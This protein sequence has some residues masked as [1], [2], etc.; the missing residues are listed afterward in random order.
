MDKRFIFPKVFFLPPMPH[1]SD[2]YILSW[3]N[4][5]RLTLNTSHYEYDF[6][7]FLF[8]NREE[9]ASLQSIVQFY[10]YGCT[11]L[12]NELDRFQTIRC[13]FLELKRQKW[14]H[15]ISISKTGHPSLQW[16]ICTPIFLWL[17]TLLSSFY[18]YCFN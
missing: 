2:E 7:K 11:S 9:N 4:K 10:I 8:Y 3:I 6:Q 12:W 16:A 1:K 18:R 14:F 15:I 5:C 13:G 17:S